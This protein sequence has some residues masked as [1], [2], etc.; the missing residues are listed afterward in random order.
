MLRYCVNCQKDYEFE[1]LAVSGKDD[2]ICP[3]CGSVVGKNSRNPARRAAAEEA[4]ER[5]G[6]F[7][8]GLFHLSYIFYMLMGALGIAG[9]FL[10][11]DLLLYIATALSV[12]VFLLQLFTGSLLFASGVFLLPLGAVLGYVYFKDLRG[13]CLG[14]HIVFLLRHLVR[15][16]FYFLF[17][18]A[19]GLIRGDGNNR[20]I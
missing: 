4:D 17:W 13:A 9:F 6:R 5:V 14:I 10:H 16:V 15:D 11:V 12:G 7:A 2:L 18:K 20:E 1:P 3:E 19:V 8:A